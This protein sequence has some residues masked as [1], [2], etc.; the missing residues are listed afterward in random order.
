MFIMEIIGPSTGGMKNHYISLVKG[1]LNSGH[2]VATVCSFESKVQNDLSKSGAIVYNICIADGSIIKLLSTTSRLVRLV[3]KLKPDIIHCHGFKA[4]AVGRLAAVLRGIR[5]V[6]TI[7]NFTLYNRSKLT[8][9]LINSFE[10]FMSRW[11]TSYITVSKALMQS[12]QEQ[13]SGRKNINVVY[14]G[15]TGI[16]AREEISIRQK[17]GIND[18]EIVLGT[19][20]RLIPSK[21]IDSLVCA[22]KHIRHHDIRLIIVGSGP[23]R[24]RIEAK[25]NELNLIDK[26]I[27]TGHVE[28]VAQYYR[29]FD[30]FVAPSL[31]EGMGI[32]VLE[33]MQFGLPI[34]AAKTGGIPELIDHNTNGIL[35]EPGNIKKI[36]EAI[37]FLISDRERTVLMGK[38]ARRDS[39]DNFTVDEML[40]KT[41]TIL[42]SALDIPS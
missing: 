23:D 13:L 11:T 14:N 6:Y 22:L 40:S 17:W 24:S 31:S 29:S 27:F 42:N 37:D 39:L 7:H 5:S 41:L 2:K 18:D 30:I 4:G 8:C 28:S 25:A 33:A 16:Q 38:R 36:A 1:L 19:V 21:G 34:I 20:G 10:R 35:V 26:I 32:S 12:V 15:L 9:R 3:K